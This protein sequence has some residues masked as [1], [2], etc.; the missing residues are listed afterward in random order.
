MNKHSAM[1]KC[2][3]VLAVWA[4]KRKMAEVCRQMG[5]ST[6]L[7]CQWQ[8]MAM[9]GMLAALEPKWKEDSIGPAMLPKLRKLMER[10]VR[11]KEG[12]LPKLERRLSK[13]AIQQKTPA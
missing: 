11:E 13:L 6:S 5:I 1:D 7:C 12:R 9:E 2:R 8:E 3:A 4:E 10:K